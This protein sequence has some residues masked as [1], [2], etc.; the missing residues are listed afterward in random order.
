MSENKKAAALFH[1]TK[2]K[3]TGTQLFASGQ[4]IFPAQKINFSEKIPVLS[5][6]MV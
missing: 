1:G 3:L 6:P 4:K 5:W 2:E